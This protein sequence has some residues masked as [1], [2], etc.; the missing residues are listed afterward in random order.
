[1]F[2]VGSGLSLD[3]FRLPSGFRLRGRVH[4]SRSGL[5]IEDPAGRGVTWFA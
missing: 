2:G 5:E 4:Q 3:K 1:M